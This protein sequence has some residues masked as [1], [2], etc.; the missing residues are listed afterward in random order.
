MYRRHHISVQHTRS[1]ARD[2]FGI[3]YLKT[4]PTTYVLHYKNGKVK[5][6][7]RGLSF[8]YYA[9][10]STLVLVPQASA[11]LPFVWTTT[12]TDFQEVTVQGQLTYRVADP[13]KLAAL[14]DFTVD[15]GGKHRAA[16]HNGPFIDTAIAANEDIVFDYD[17]IGVDGLQDATDLRG[18]AEVHALAH[19]RARTD[20]RV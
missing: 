4:P 19:L 6:E 7:G 8:L 11:D 10:T 5:R 9:P 12:T 20:Q 13:K 3:A 1:E 18:G 15:A 16:S 2:R 17:R 14:L